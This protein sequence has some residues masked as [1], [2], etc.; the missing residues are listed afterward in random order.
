[1]KILA[2]D[3]SSKNASVS[4]LEDYNIL[5]ELNND[6]EKT[7]SQKL[8]PMISDAFLQSNLTLDDIDLICC[9]LGPG[10]FTGV[11][12]GIAT[13]KAFVD[14]KNIP[15]V[16]ISSLE[17]LAYNL[18]T[19]GIICSLI[20]AKNGNV[21][22][23]IFEIE[24]TDNYFKT[25][26]NNM[27]FISLKNDKGDFSSKSIEYFIN[28]FKIS[29]KYSTITFVGDGSTLYKELLEKLNLKYKIV[30]ENETVLSS[31]TIAK[32]G[33]T[34]YNNGEFGDSSILSPIYLRKSQAEIALE[35]KK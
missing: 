9:G 25:V 16:G 18:N 35:N 30:I 11:R 17:A 15:T 14:S 21:Y 10:S 23:G 7:H 8:M 4:I 32:I 33:Y 19:D 22:A 5:T 31:I 20:D 34:K 27:D 12:I 6:D 24:K 28:D 2:L 1:M 26:K 13:A 3:S 29:D